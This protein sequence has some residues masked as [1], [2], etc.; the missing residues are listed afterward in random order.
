MAVR[1]SL[2][3]RPAASG[4]GVTRA[5]GPD[6][7]GRSTGGR[8]R[9][10]RPA[11]PPVDP[12]WAPRCV[13]YVD[14][15]PALHPSL[16]GARSTVRARYRG[17]V[18]RTTRLR[19]AR[20]HRRGSAMSAAPIAVTR[21]TIRRD[22]RPA[23]R[24]L[25]PRSTATAVERST[26]P[27]QGPDARP[28]PGPPGRPQ[29]RSGA[30]AASRS[31]VRLL[32]GLAVVAVAARRA[33]RRRARVRHASRRSVGGVVTGFIEGVTA[34]PVPSATP[35]VAPRS[36]SIAVPSEPY[37]NQD[38]VDLTVTVDRAVVGDADY[39]RPGLPG[40][41]GPGAGADRGGP[42]GRDAADDHP[43][44]ADRRASTTSRSPSS[45]PAASRSQSPLVRY[46]LDQS[47]PPIK[48]ASPRDGATSTA[49]R[50]TCRAGPR[51]ARRSWR[52]T[53]T[54]ATRSAAR[55]TA[56]A[57]SRSG[58]RIATGAQPHRHHRHRPGRQRQRAGADGQSRARASCR[59]RWRRRLSHQAAARCPAPS[60]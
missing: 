19:H 1:R 48:L 30:A 38:T 31:P 50:S 47:K 45:G 23:I 22:G 26:R 60:S 32:L 27:R 34:T 43:G 57:P 52:A 5:I 12:P 9:R 51:L 41:R 36:P 3:P 20:R 54:P 11:D 8:R 33:L 59:R 53:R 49:R 7:E 46:V 40:P 35:I 21:A 6:A 29:P 24:S 42:A 10:A 58:C 18:Q 56:T 17:R 16:T 44:R 4:D 39:Q 15:G 37:T 55:P 14:P 2:R 28:G 13:R 25:Q